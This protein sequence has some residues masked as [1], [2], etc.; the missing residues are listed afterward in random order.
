MVGG[1]D[2]LTSCPLSLKRPFSLFAFSEVL[3]CCSPM[4]LLLSCAAALLWCCSP[5]VL[6]LSYCAAALF[7]FCCSPIVLQL[8]CAAAALLCCSILGLLLLICYLQS[9]NCITKFYLWTMNMIIMASMRKGTKLKPSD[10]LAG[11]DFVPNLKD[12]WQMPCR[13]RGRVTAE[14]WRRNALFSVRNGETSYASLRE[15]TSKYEQ[16]NVYFV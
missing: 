9:V 15:Q 5:L 12:L 11:W 3:C 10:R 4:L 2:I 8:S 14:K 7:L 6:L 13:K 16:G 1:R